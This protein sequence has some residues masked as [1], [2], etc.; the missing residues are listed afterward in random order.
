MKHINA[1]TS[2][3]AFAALLVFLFHYALPAALRERPVDNIFHNI[4]NEGH[5]G[6][7]IFFALSGFLLTVRYLEDVEGRRLRLTDYFVRR[8]ARILPLYFTV[9]LLVFLIGIYDAPAPLAN[10]TLTQAFFIDL[11][12]TGISTAW[13]LT[14]E[15]AFYALLPLILLSIVWTRRRAPHPR[16]RLVLTVACLLVWGVAV[17]ALGV[18]LVAWLSPHQAVT[19]GLMGSQEHMVNFTIFGNL[20]CFLAGIA[21]ALVF[22]HNP[23][24]F[25]D[26]HSASWRGLPLS[27]ASIGIMLWS[28]VQLNAVPF[29]S[30]P[31]YP[32]AITTAAGA[33]LLIL[34]LTAARNPLARLM[35]WSPLVYLGKVSYAFYLVHF[36]PIMIVVYGTV[37]DTMQAGTGVT[38]LVMGGLGLIISMALYELVERPAQALILR[39]YAERT[40]KRRVRETTVVKV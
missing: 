3:R 9:L 24:A 6:V 33:A 8:V 39:I 38:L 36:L 23:L 15:E 31:A 10:L 28:M 19:F 34:S 35:E 2:L 32:Y 30:L 37:R 1:L 17:L 40:A 20:F 29:E 11:N 25:T 14:N 22:K 26:A 7:E 27:L 16:W 18:V 13:S 21:T 4:F 12:F 5:L